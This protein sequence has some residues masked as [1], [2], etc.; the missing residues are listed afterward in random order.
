MYT[1]N[2]QPIFSY[3]DGTVG[4]NWGAANSGH[5]GQEYTDVSHSATINLAAGTGTIHVWCNNWTWDWDG[6]NGTF[7]ATL[8]DATNVSTTMPRAAMEHVVLNYSTD[9]AQ[10][11]TITVGNAGTNGNAG[12]YAL[13]VS[14]APVPEPGTCVLIATGLI[15]LACYAW[16]KR[17]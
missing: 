9:V 2:T 5:V 12:F 11:L 1:D 7:D 6:T 17:K 4:S 16:R 15:G 3:A 8:A 14:A 13:A 10:S